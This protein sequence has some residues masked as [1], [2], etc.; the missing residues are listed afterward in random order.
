MKKKLELYDNYIS[1]VMETWTGENQFKRARL[2]LIEE[3]GEILGKYKKRLRGD[4][5][6]DLELKKELGDA[7]YYCRILQKLIGENIDYEILELSYNL[8]EYSI[9]DN[10][11]L[12]L[13]LAKCSTGRVVQY[14]ATYFLLIKRLGFDFAEILEIN[15]QKLQSRKK[16][17]KIKGSGDNR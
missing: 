7:I 14:L 6:S 16:R 15:R 1:Q 11:I 8:F 3:T 17:G 2:G 13:N 9:L 12:F 5:V 10:H 4:N